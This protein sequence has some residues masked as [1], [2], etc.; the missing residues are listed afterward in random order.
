[1]TLDFIYSP[2][3]RM[4]AEDILY[5][6]HPSHP[7]RLWLTGFLY[8]VCGLS[9]RD[10]KKL[11][12]YE[13][14]WVDYKEDETDK[15]VSQ[16]CN[17]PSDFNSED[18]P[19]SKNVFVPL[20]RECRDTS[21]FAKLNKRFFKDAYK[22]SY[23]YALDNFNVYG[24]MMWF[25]LTYPIYRTI[26]GRDHI[27][28]ALDIDCREDSIAYGFEVSKDIVALDNWDFF[29]Y[30]GSKGFHI[31]KKEHNKTRQELLE[32]AEEI[33]ETVKTNLISFTYDK[34]Y[35]KSVNIDPSMYNR[36]RFIRGYCL[37]LRSKAYSI[38]VNTDMRIEEVLE[39]SKDLNKIKEVLS[40]S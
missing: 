37:N 39:L 24:S 20:Y 14:N 2:K 34:D 40:G 16:I 19:L 25:P 11:Y 6:T 22:C 29:K 28:F 13:S 38:P 23:E 32:K 5:S 3:H 12:K 33:Y 10:I 1:M 30:S 8:N 4:N 17:E 18:L 15:Q 31:I 7:Q 35:V 36:G 21:I 9:S 26:E 27:L